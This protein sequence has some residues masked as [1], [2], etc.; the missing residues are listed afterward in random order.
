MR[1]LI[2]I[3]L[4]LAVAFAQ[5]LPDQSYSQDLARKFVF[6]AGAAYCY[7][8]EIKNWDCGRPCDEMRQSIVSDDI[9]YVGNEKLDTQSYVSVNTER[10]TVTLTIRGTWNKYNWLALNLDFLKTKGFAGCKKC[11]VHK[12]FLKAWNSLR[13]EAIFNI[14]DLMHKYGLKQL[15]IT[16]HSLGAAVATLAALDL[17][18]YYDIRNVYTFGQPR[19]GD[20][21]TAELIEKRLGDRYWRVTHYGDPV[22]HAAPHFDGYRHASTE[23]W[24]NQASNNSTSH[25]ICNG[26]GEDPNCSDS[27]AHPIHVTEYWENQHANY[28]GLPLYCWCGHKHLRFCPHGEPHNTPRR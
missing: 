19:V 14:K 5:N 6:L 25:V 9:R 13:D 28:V 22:P 1:I 16:G 21:I 17:D 12:G 8:D 23:V 4:I 18:Q 15:D 20:E 3:C 27:L 10:Q 7:P 26:S 24:Y 11:S 2:A